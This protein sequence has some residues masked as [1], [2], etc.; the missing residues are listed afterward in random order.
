MMTMKKVRVT[1]IQMAMPMERPTVMATETTNSEDS[2]PKRR[3]ADARLATGRQDFECY[4][5]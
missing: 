4:G 5:F 1:E 2:E 3:R